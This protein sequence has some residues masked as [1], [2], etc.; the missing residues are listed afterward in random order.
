MARINLLDLN[1]GI[2]NVMDSPGRHLPCRGPAT[3]RP[4]QL[5]EAGLDEMYAPSNAGRIMEDAL[6]PEVGDGTLLEPGVFSANLAR[7]A[8]KLRERGDAAAEELVREELLPLLE[9][10]KML[11]AYIGLMIGG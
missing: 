7:C 8:D 1:L 6:R 2:Q 3:G 11:S 5:S 4:P 9:N 10:K